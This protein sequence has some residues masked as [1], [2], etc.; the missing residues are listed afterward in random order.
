[1][2]WARRAWALAPDNAG[3]S[4]DARIARMAMTTNNSIKVKAGLPV[5]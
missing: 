2:H 3:S 5:I 4:I 1:M